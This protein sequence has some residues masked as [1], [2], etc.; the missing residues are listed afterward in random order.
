MPS[1]CDAQDGSRREAHAPVWTDQTADWRSAGNYR[2]AAGVSVSAYKKLE[3]GE[4]GLS[5]KVL[6]KLRKDNISSDY[7]LFGDIRPVDKLWFEVENSK[8]DEKLEILLR[9]IMDCS[10][11]EVSGEEISE[12][13]MTNLI[14]AIF[15]KD[16]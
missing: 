6:R 7:L 13:K 15:C 12:E 11:D 16:K 4:N 8:K 5:T 9:L 10:R 2:H 3:S 14:S 1:F